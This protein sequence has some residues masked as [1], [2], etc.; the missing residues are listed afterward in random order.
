MRRT[1]VPD[2]HCPLLDGVVTLLVARARINRVTVVETL[3][4]G[5]TL[6]QLDTHDGNGEG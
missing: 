5:V 4:D 1:G 2:Q 3:A 6:D